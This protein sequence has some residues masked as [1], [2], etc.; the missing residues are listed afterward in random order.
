MKSTTKKTLLALAA[1]VVVVA[2][3]AMAYGL[4]GT[5]TRDIGPTAGNNAV[6]PAASDAQLVEAGRYLAVTADCIACH[7]AKGGKPFAGGLTMATPIGSLYS[8][9]ITPDKET[10]IGNY[11]LNDFDRAIRHGIVPSGKTLYPAMPY[12]SYAKISDQDVRALYAYFM[13][14]VAPVRQENKG[15]AI[16]WPLS[17]NWPLAIWR[18]TYAPEVAPMVLTKYQSEAIAR[19]A[20]LVQ[21]LGHCGACHTPR[22]VTM[23]E[24]AL[25]DSHP[26][27]LSGGPVIDGWLAVNLRANSASGLGRWSEKDIVD[28]LAKARNDHSAV[29]GSPMAEV[30]AHSTQ[31]MTPGDQSA[32]AAYLKSLPVG[33]EEKA[34]Y[35]ASDATAV[36]LKAGHDEN[37]G[38][39]LYL[40]NC[41]ACHRTDAKSNGIVFPALAGN[42]SVLSDNPTSLIRLILAGSA[43]PSTKTAPSNLGMPAFGW[44]LSDD[45]TAQLV[46]FVRQSW[47]NQASA[48]TAGEVGKIRKLLKE[49][50]DQ[51]GKMAANPTLQAH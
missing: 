7:S 20:Y 25:D 27:F 44:R 37:R 15:S 18:K 29:V 51:A 41:A 50:S 1:I 30:V 32:I 39:Q 9:N 16:R 34:R 19:G 3:G 4:S 45:E 33:L 23:Q 22:A 31:N 49:E 17:I 28:T 48:A 13:H 47:G 36:A 24:L 40:D 14:G 21:G 42:P 26:A 6:N 38:A 11:T 5:T 46:T 8:S 12:P 2:G 10:G 35:A 43:L